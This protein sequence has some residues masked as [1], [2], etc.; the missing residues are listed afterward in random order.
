MAM[1]VGEATRMIDA[2]R[3][4]GVCL[5]VAENVPYEPQSKLLREIVQSGKY[6]GGTTFAVM[7]KGFRAPAFAYEGRRDWLTDP[8]KGGT[9]AW[10]LQGIHSMAQVRYVFGEVASV[11]MKEHHL[12]SFRRAD[13]EGTMCGLLT[14]ASGV[15]V[16]V[17]QT[18]ETRMHGDTGGY[19]VY[20]EK[21]VLRASKRGCEV[22]SEEC[23]DSDTAVR[24]EY[25]A[26]QLS[27]YAEE[28]EAFVGAVAGSGGGPTTAE[29]ERR[30][31][32]VVQAGYE[33]AASG[34]PVDLSQR[35]A[36]L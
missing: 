2:A 13:I 22:F 8:G 18:T 16:A 14:M 27:S 9:G 7:V 31:L 24:L 4:A 11:Y 29:G 34:K 5:F 12:G 33:S 20:G 10:M 25:P 19:V 3:H 17:V 23:G 36:E 26:Q 6:I 30:S 28:I 21:G 15:N 1:N 32:A 35:F